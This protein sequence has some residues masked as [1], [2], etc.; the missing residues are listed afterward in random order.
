MIQISQQ[1]SDDVMIVMPVDVYNALVT[2][3]KDT[4]EDEDMR[5]VWEDWAADA[6]VELN[7]AMQSD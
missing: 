5:I 6:I 1:T 4:A 7:E 3:V 2:V